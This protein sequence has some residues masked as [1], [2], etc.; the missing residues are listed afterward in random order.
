MKHILI[1]TFLLFPVLIIN[2]QD[3][4]HEFTSRDDSVKLKGL[5]LYLE[6]D[7]VYKTN[8]SSGVKFVLEIINEGNNLLMLTN[9]LYN[10]QLYINSSIWLLPS[11]KKLQI[12]EVSRWP[13]P[14][15]AEGI[16]PYRLEKVTISG[17]EI[18]D[19]KHSY[20]WETDTLEIE[21]KQRIRYELNLYEHVIF[22]EEI[23]FKMYYEPLP[24]GKYYVI[25]NVS[26]D[27]GNYSIRSRS[28]RFEMRLE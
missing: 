20:F 10:T 24:K 14:R 26:L 23:R 2:A 17:E 12:K 21:P 19:N 6:I 18:A 15:L 27:M 28:L 8:N 5:K 9:P 25:F 3:F 13:N 4:R 16:K 11:K 7:S 1:L 22:D